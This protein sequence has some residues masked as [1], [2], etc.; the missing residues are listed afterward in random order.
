[1]IVSQLD[2]HGGHLF[3]IGSRRRTGPK[4][5]L[6]CA[7]DKAGNGLRCLRKIGAP[8]LSS[9]REL[10]RSARRQGYR[11]GL[12]CPMETLRHRT[13]ASSVAGIEEGWYYLTLSL[14]GPEDSALKDPKSKDLGEPGDDPA[15]RPI[16][17]RAIAAAF[18][19]RRPSA[20]SRNDIEV[21]SAGSFLPSGFHSPPDD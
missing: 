21:P 1:M 15:Y 7:P 9:R 10:G 19:V 14:R 20:S 3:E 17:F 11:G 6:P 16:G 8:P 5:Q 4:T 13:A 2:E 18:S 12:V